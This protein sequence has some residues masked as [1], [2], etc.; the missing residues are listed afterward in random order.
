MILMN[1]CE[2][3]GIKIEFKGKRPIRRPR[4]RGIIRIMTFIT[5][6]L[7]EMKELEQ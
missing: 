6:Q 7:T 5:E 4:T 3:N 1:N 2:D